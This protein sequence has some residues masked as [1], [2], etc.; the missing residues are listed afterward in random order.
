MSC[1]A[2]WREL[3]F[4]QYQPVFQL[5]YIRHSYSTYFFL[6]DLE[7]NLNRVDLEPLTSLKLFLQPYSQYECATLTAY[8][9]L[10]RVQ[11]IK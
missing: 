9:T 7:S 2:K 11:S 3:L 6:V 4:G 10:E 5:N 8:V 1:R